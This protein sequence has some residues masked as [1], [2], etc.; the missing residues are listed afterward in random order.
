MTRAPRVCTMCV[1]TLDPDEDDSV[2]IPYV[3]TVWT[4]WC[5]C[6]RCFD[7]ACNEPAPGDER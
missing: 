1:R 4:E 3:E 5:V 6:R 7:R 2:G